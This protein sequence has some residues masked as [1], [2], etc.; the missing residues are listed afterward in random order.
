MIR[1]PLKLL[2]R[3]GECKA[4]GSHE[5]LSAEWQRRRCSRSA[6][7]AATPQE[8]SLLLF[9]ELATKGRPPSSKSLI[10]PNSLLFYSDR[11]FSALLKPDTLARSSPTLRLRAMLQASPAAADH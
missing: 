7:V 8:M 2:W 1:P 3:L 4:M 6:V 10:I 9:C 11:S 5:R